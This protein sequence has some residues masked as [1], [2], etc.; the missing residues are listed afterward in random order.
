M[1]RH[2][3]ET[4]LRVVD[5]VVKAAPWFTDEMAGDVIGVGVVSRGRY[6]QQVRQ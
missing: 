5:K 6:I 2:D 4:V 3:I 1:R